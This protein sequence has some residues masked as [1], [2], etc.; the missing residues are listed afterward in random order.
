MLSVG[1]VKEVRVWSHA[2]DEFSQHVLTVTHRDGRNVDSVLVLKLRFPA[3]QLP[4]M[5]N[6]R[7]SEFTFEK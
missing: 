7:F 4:A 6:V 2:E 3:H 5:G 1:R